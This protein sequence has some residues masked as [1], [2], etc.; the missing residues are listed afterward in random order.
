MDPMAMPQMMTR[1][2][3]EATQAWA[4]RIAGFG[5]FLENPPQVSVGETPADVIYSENKLR[6]LRY[7]PERGAIHPTPVLIVY[8]LINR[9]Y[10]LDLQHD[11][12]VVRRLLEAGLDVYLIDW[13]SPSQ[14][15]Q[16]LTL[17]DYVNR[18]LENCVDA[19]R[20]KSGSSDV[21]VLGYCMGGAMST[22]YAALHPEKVR[23]LVLMAAP[24]VFDGGDGLLRLWSRPEYFDADK[25]VEAFGNAPGGF[26]DAGFQFLKPVENMYAKYANFA[27]YAGNEEFVANFLRMEQWSRDTIPVAGETYRQFIKELYQSNKLARNELALDGKPVRLDGLMMPLLLLTGKFDHL[28]PNES[29][30]A[31]LEFVPSTDKEWIDVPTGHIGLSVSSRAHRDVWPKVCEWIVARSG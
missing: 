7:R 25:I 22:M 9:P 27:K 23:N 4:D 30:S 3:V 13:G 16:W 14:I 31:F 26:L 18:Y 21:T 28:V 2:A 24:L 20:V 29:T 11:R 19:V 10:V 15:D 1:A 17:D 6:L 8:A 12:S 5:T